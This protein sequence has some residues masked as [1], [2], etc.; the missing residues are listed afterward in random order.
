MASSSIAAEQ[1]TRTQQTE[2]M[3]ASSPLSVQPRANSHE[4]AAS[5]SAALAKA[6]IEAKFVI[7]LQRPRSILAAR[8]A[9]LEACKR[10]A[11]AEGAMYW[12]KQ[13]RRPVGDGDQWEDNFVEG[14]SIRFAEQ[15]LSVWRNVD[16]TVITAWEDDQSRIVRITVTDLETNLSYS[17]EVMLSKT[18]ERRSVRAG[19]EVVSERETSSGHRVFIVKAT[20]DELS[21]KV[22]A[23]KSKV[24]RNSGWR[25]IPQD[26]LEEAETVIRETREKGGDDPKARLKRL[27]DAFGEIGVPPTELET[28]L[29]HP[30]EQTTPKEVASLRSIYTAIRD[31]E[32]RWADYR[33]RPESAA[34]EAPAG[35][36]A[37]PAPQHS[38]PP[39]KGAN[40]TRGP[41]SA[42]PDA[43][44]ASAAHT[45]QPNPATPQGSAP[46]RRN[47]G[48][49]KRILE[50]EGLTEA[51]A[52]ECVHRMFP[53]TAQCQGL[54]DVEKSC[55]QV[56]VAIT[57]GTGS[58]VAAVRA[59]GKPT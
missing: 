35:P 4:I 2:S 44:P 37:R 55:P 7:A 41:G 59:G 18:V 24:I 17:D 12:K 16:V 5:A 53:E 43:A 28:Y 52:M 47:L 27:T 49:V 48:A 50:R 23:A 32:A 30:L 15:A 11:F 19:Q 45:P 34:G 58:F 1:Q 20:D 22:N 51:A 21:N 46:E 56:L 3:S 38:A 13:G 40:G 33:S 14:F 42:G 36:E 31:G 26:I 29:G 54:E 25:L 9:I 57:R 8:A 39:D 6:T 10:P